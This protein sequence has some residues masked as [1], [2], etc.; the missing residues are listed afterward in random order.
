MY[1]VICTTVSTPIGPSLTCTH[2]DGAAFRRLMYC[3]YSSV[4]GMC[5]QSSSRVTSARSQWSTSN[6]S[7]AAWRIRVSTS[8]SVSSTSVPSLLVIFSPTF[9]PV[10]SGSGR[11]YGTGSTLSMYFS[12]S[13]SRLPSSRCAYG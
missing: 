3:R 8:S 12:G 5:T 10:F 4:S 2:S 13:A 11:M 6:R 9:S 7:C 1:P